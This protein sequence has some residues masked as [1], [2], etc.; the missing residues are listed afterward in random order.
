MVRCFKKN[1]T[2]IGTILLFQKLLPLL[3]ETHH[4]S[5]HRLLF[6]WL[7]QGQ[8]IDI[9]QS[10]KHTQVANYLGMRS[11]LSLLGMHFHLPILPHCPI[12][13]WFMAKKKWSWYFPRKLQKSR[14]LDMVCRPNLEHFIPR[15]HETIF[16]EIVPNVIIWVISAGSLQFWLPTTWVSSVTGEWTSCQVQEITLTKIQI[17][18]FKLK[19][20]KLN[21]TLLNIYL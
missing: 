11:Y 17:F 19:N 13:G 18:D 4:G 7:A 8:D 12:N 16:L 3:L 15:I 14:E 5:L 1:P 9:I 10:F 21:L 20:F 2:R 6:I